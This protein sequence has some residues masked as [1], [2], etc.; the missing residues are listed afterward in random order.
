[1]AAMTKAHKKAMAVGRRQSRAVKLYLEALERGR[2]R[3]PK[4]TPERL[5][6]RIADAEAAIGS[7]DDPVKRLQ[8]IQDRMDD[9]ERLE[10]LR[11][12]PDHEDLEQ[13]FVDVAADYGERKGISYK[14]WREL[15]V[16]AATLKTAGIPRSA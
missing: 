12:E 11:N 10:E 8:L 3:G 9:E 2:K 14:A 4:V 6:A 7:E 16:P 1:M 13:A 5:Q 15:G